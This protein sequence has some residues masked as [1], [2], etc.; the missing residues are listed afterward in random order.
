MDRMLAGVLGW[1]IKAGHLDLTFDDG[2][3]VAMEGDQPG[4]RAAVQLHKPGLIRAIAVGGSNALTEA[5]MRGDLDTDDLAE[6]LTVAALNQHRWA[7]AHP[8]LYELGRNVASRMPSRLPEVAVDTMAGHYNLGNDF[9]AAWLDPTMTYSAGRFEEPDA[10][11]EEA[12]RAK[13]AAMARLAD[14]QPGQRVLEIGSGWGAFAVYAAELGCHVTTLT[15]ADRQAEHVEQLARRHGLDERIE[16]QVR[17]FME[18][19][20]TYDR[21]VSI[22]MI[23]SI[24]EARWPEYFATIAAVLEP[25]GRAGLQAIVIDDDAYDSYR[26]NEDFIRR[27][28]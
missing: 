16:V 20:E 25:G 3:R 9:Y 12:Q 28:I 13:Y 21:V 14:L 26:T 15:I 18:V 8:R 1:G 11:L 4:P 6:F 2:T 23:E 24:D 27:Y 5:Y 7:G 22:E 19:T 10:T 17:D